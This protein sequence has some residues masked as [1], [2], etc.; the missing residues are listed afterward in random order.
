MRKI[1]VYLPRQR[2]DLWEPI[3]PHGICVDLCDLWENKKHP[4][5]S[6]AHCALICRPQ[7]SQISTDELD[8]AELLPPVGRWVYD[9]SREITS[10]WSVCFARHYLSTVGGAV[11]REIINTG[12]VS[13]RRHSIDS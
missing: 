6:L 5:C 10:C 11:I 4:A 2:R 12:G 3:T 9:K 7:I 13:L 8:Y 1:R